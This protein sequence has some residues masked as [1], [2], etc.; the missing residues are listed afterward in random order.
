MEPPPAGGKRYSSAQKFVGLEF[1]GFF[2]FVVGGLGGFSPIWALPV[3]TVDRLE[4]TSDD[5]FL[6]LNA[7][8]MF[9][10]PERPGQTLAC[11]RR[12]IQETI[13]STAFPSNAGWLVV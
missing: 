11:Q 1:G 7:G 5:L 13:F 8:R 6:E 10:R 12:R 3:S 4:E 9:L 2:I